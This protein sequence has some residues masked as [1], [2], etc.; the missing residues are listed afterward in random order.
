MLHALFLDQV[1]HWSQAKTYP[2][3]PNTN[4]NPNPKANQNWNR[5]PK[6]TP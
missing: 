4:T 5:N 6:Y 2:H 1:G 3:T